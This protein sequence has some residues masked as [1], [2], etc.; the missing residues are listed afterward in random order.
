MEWCFRA[1][2]DVCKCRQL[3]GY[4]IVVVPPRATLYGVLVADLTI[5]YDGVGAARTKHYSHIKI[6]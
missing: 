6:N 2:L 5:C 1:L 3:V 4:R